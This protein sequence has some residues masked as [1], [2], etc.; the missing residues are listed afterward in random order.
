V[1]NRKSVDHGLPIKPI[2]NPLGCDGNANMENAS[3]LARQLHLQLMMMNNSRL[4]VVVGDLSQ[5]TNFRPYQ[6]YSL[7]SYTC[8]ANYISIPNLHT[9]SNATFLPTRFIVSVK[10]QSFNHCAC[11]MEP[12]SKYHPCADILSISVD[13]HPLIVECAIC[14]TLHKDERKEHVCAGR[15]STMYFVCLLPLICSMNYLLKVSIIPW[16]LRL[17]SK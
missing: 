8:M 7:L 11:T 3:F 12:V 16:I 10:Q 14:C 4:E 9:Y 2:H 6:L 5:G 15:I 1:V 17:F 13:Y